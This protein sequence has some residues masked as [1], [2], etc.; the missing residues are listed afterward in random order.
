MKTSKVNKKK[1]FIGIILGFVFISI[2]LVSVSFRM[3]GYESTADSIITWLFVVY[4][5]AYCISTYFYVQ[6][7]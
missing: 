2:A 4:A 3:R 1:L 5:V 7:N 6:N